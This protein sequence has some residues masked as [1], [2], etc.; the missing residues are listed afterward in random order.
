MKPMN[1]I[2]VVVVWLVFLWPSTLRAQ[3]SISVS[4]KVSRQEF[5]HLPIGYERTDRGILMRAFLTAQVTSLNNFLNTYRFVHKQLPSSAVRLKDFLHAVRYHSD[6]IDVDSVFNRFREIT[7]VQ[8]DS[9]TVDLNFDCYPFRFDSIAV[10]TYNGML[11]IT[12][13]S[14]TSRI[15]LWTKSFRAFDYGANRAI[16]IEEKE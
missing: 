13:G 6:E 7:F 8:H 2:C 4:T 3:D 5:S 15:Y 9:S 12:P 14:D 11:R 1:V 16:H 10:D